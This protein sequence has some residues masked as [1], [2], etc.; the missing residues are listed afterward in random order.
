MKL[1]AVGEC[2]HQFKKDNGPY[3]V[4]MI[5]LLAESHLSI[6]T[7]VDEGKIRLDYL[8]VIY[9]LKIEIFKKLLVIILM[10]VF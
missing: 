10:S 5:Y 9:H 7:F 3:G 2:S 6:H 8:H 4:T 1:N